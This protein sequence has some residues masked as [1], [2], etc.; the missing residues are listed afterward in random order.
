MAK[1]K[2]IKY[3]TSQGVVEFESPST[4]VIAGKPR[5]GIVY[6]DPKVEESYIA[7]DRVEESK[8]RLR[9]EGPC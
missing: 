8:R 1:V 2:P 7:Y 6:C 5:H 4:V 3:D 9:E